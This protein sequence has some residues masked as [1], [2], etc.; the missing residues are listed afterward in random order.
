MSA[1]GHLEPGASVF[2]LGIVTPGVL[3]DAIDL[4]RLDDTTYR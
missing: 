2:T 4:S 3:P 1:G